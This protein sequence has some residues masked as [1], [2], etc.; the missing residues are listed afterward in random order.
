MT[1]HRF[2]PKE[3]IANIEEQA[4][5]LI[6]SGGLTFNEFK[7]CQSMGI[8]FTK[9]KLKKLKAQYAA[10]TQEEVKRITA[11]Y[12]KE[13]DKINAVSLEMHAIFKNIK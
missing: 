8:K 12:Q 9:A 4:I 2:L 5:S 1:M 10:E 7:E 3:T 11:E 6:A 13:A